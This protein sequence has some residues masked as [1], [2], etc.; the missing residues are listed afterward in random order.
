MGVGAGANPK[1]VSVQLAA[2]PAWPT[3]DQATKKTRRKAGP[4]LG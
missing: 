3:S 2:V 4:E 1:E